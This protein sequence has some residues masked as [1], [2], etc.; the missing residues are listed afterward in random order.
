MVGMSKSNSKLQG[1][2]NTACEG[3]LQELTTQI[4]SFFESVTADFQPVTPREVIHIAPDCSV[5]E[6]FTIT[7]SDV[8]KQLSRLN[9]NKASGPDGVPAWFL[10]EYAELLSGPVCCIFNSSMRDGYI[11]VVWKSADVCPLAKVPARSLIEK[12][13]QPISLTPVLVKCL[14]RHVTGCILDYMD[15]S[16][17]PHKFGSLQGSSTVHALVELVHLWHKALDTPGN[18]V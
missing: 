5:P 3:N 13:L 8:E 18:M 7:V 15:G 1:L 4:N 9:T 10:K 16:I 2:A 6:R 17:D 11:P 14:E 12:H